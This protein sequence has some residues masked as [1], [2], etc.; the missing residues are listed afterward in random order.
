MARPPPW[1]SSAFLGL[2]C[3][4]TFPWRLAVGSTLCDGFGDSYRLNIQQNL[5]HV[6]DADKLNLVIQLDVSKSIGSSLYRSEVERFAFD[7]IEFG[8]R[9][10]GMTIDSDHAWIHIYT[11]RDVATS[12][13]RYDARITASL[14]TGLAVISKKPFLQGGF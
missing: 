11:F 4:I 10:K 3:I 6:F 14:G 9:K 2:L 12:Q 8:V 13:V 7:L 1:S 5:D